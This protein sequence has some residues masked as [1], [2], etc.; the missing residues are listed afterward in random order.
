MIRSSYESSVPATPPEAGP[1][2][3]TVTDTTPPAT[4][5]QQRFTTGFAFTF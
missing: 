4:Y 5:L 2:T 3:V 1:Y